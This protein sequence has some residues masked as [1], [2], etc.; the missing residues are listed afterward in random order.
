VRPSRSAGVDSSRLAPFG[1]K[2]RTYERRA[3]FRLGPEQRSFPRKR[4]ALRSVA[5][6]TACRDPARHR[7]SAYTQ[8]AHGTRCGVESESKSGL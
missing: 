8:P 3:S 1:I 2:G 7:G 5:V 4:L 6:G